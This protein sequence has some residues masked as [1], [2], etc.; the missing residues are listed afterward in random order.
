MNSWYGKYFKERSDFSIRCK[1]TLLNFD[2]SQ[3]N[4]MSL[5]MTTEYLFQNLK[6]S[7][8]EASFFLFSFLYGKMVSTTS[9]NTESHECLLIEFL[10]F[11]LSQVVVGKSC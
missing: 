9:Y 2:E 1:H 8:I 3:T 4:F 6:M 5:I 10:N 7:P 11:T